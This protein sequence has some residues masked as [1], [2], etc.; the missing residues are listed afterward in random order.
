M[1]RRRE[2]LS[3]GTTL[4]FVSHNIEQVRNLC[5]HAVWLDHGEARMQGDIN[6]VCNAYMEEMQK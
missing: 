1:K 6:T 4:L 3:G 2:L 5:D